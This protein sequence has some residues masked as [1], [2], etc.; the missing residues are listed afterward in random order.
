MPDQAG[1]VAVVTGATAGIGFATAKALAERG[2]H[3]VLAV[4]DP[5]RGAD[6]AARIGGSTPRRPAASTAVRAGSAS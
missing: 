4:R 5:V 6:A 1:R 2:C 3:V